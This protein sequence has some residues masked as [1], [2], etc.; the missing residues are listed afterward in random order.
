MR[1]KWTVG[2]LVCALVPV[3]AGAQ[4]L[5]VGRRADG[6]FVFSNN[7][8]RP[9]EPLLAGGPSSSRRFQ[10]PVTAPRE[11]RQRI[12]D[13]A[14]AQDLDPRLVEA[15]IRVESAFDVRA[16]SHKGAMGLMQ[17]MPSTAVD[18]GVE[19]AFDVDQNLRGGTAYLRKL[20]DRF[21]GDLTL[22]LAGYNAGPG[23]VDRYRGVP[24]YRETTDYVRRVLA[25]YGAPAAGTA[26]RPV[27][28]VGSAVSRVASP[29]GIR[30]ASD[31]VVPDRIVPG[32]GR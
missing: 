7:P 2:A 3:V 29:P 21:R 27:V 17:L 18:L 30:T 32:A 4:E 24:P 10:H 12:T 25:A 11:L 16:I 22:A 5:S 9:R 19:N 6:V 15:V 20:L 28:P 23:A 8:D 26:G 1:R 14:L 13:H 31:R